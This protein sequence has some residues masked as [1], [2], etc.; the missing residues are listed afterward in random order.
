[1]I[2]YKFRHL[3]MEGGEDVTVG[4]DEGG[5]MA[6]ASGEVLRGNDTDDFPRLGLDEEDFGVVVG[7]IG[8]LHRLG[9]E[10]P[11]FEGLVGG[12]VVEDEVEGGDVARLLDEEESS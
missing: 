10:S 5:L 8:A 1:M 12:F 9:D 4:G 2:L 7:E 11:E 6:V 3:G